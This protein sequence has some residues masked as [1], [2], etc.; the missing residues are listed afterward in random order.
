M[1]AHPVLNRLLKVGGTVYQGSG[2][3]DVIL[4]TYTSAGALDQVG[5][6]KGGDDEVVTDI[7]FN[8]STN[9]FYVV[10]NFKSSVLNY[11]VGNALENVQHRF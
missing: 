2:L 5:E 10:G 9:D 3:N 6:I 7:S 1:R 8:T 11:G 4:L